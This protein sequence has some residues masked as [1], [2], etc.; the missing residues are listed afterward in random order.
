[1]ALI[2]K[3]RK[4]FWLLLLVIGFALASF[5]LMD[6]QGPGGGAGGNT[7]MGTINGQKIDYQDYQLTESVYYQGSQGETFSKRANIWNFFVEQSLLKGVSDK[8]GL[9]VGQ[10]EMMDLQFG[11]D[12]SPIMRQNWASN[13]QILSQY[14]TQVENGEMQGELAQFWGEQ[15]KQI[16]KAKIQD[17]LSNLVSKGIYTPNWMAEA[18]FKDNN[19][20]VDFQ[21]VKIPFDAITNQVEVTDADYQNHINKYPARFT[22]KVE[23]RNIEYTVFDVIPTAKDSA[24]IRANINEMLTTFRSSDNDSIFAL[25]KSGFYSPVYLKNS[26]LPESMQETI[27]SVADGDVYGPYI[28]QGNYNLFKRIASINVA[29]TVKAQQI[30]INAD[31]SNDIQVANANNKIDSLERLFKRGI[32]FD[33]LAIKNSQD[34]TAFNGGDMG[35]ITQQG[36][37][38]ANPDLANAIFY[39]G[40]RKGVYKVKSRQG[41]HLVKI[42]EI[43]YSDDEP[44]YK[45]AMVGLPIVPSEETQRRISG[46]VSDLIIAH[47]GSDKNVGTLSAALSEQGKTF[48]VSSPVKENDYALDAL[49]AGATSR[50]IIKWA[51]DEIREVGDISQNVHTFSDPI[52]YHESKYV[53]ASLKSINPKGMQSVESLKSSFNWFSFCSR[54]RK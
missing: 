17:K 31:L 15:S 48:Q 37:Y 23:T 8:L 35:I 27:K 45:I 32:S 6:A 5:I 19:T 24:D 3:I 2:T 34:N 52:N 40:R 50:E 38:Q 9:S 33:S 25:Q 20:K 39:Q 54:N 10:E 51:F 22:E 42:N 14:K 1:M 26:T 46:E 29:D 11:A 47:N 12:Q 7:L 13:P 28:D 44:E 49:G 41:I 43:V 30:L 4:N 36:M 18:S 21:Y 16:G 53:I